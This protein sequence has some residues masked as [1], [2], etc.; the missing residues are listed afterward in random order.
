MEGPHI[1]IARPKYITILYP[2]LNVRKE[3]REKVVNILK[4]SFGVLQQYNF[5]WEWIGPTIKNGYNTL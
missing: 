3:N 4:G 5:K 2:A 1:Y